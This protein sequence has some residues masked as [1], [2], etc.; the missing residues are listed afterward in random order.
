MIIGHY[1]VG[2]VEALAKPDFL[3]CLPVA[4]HVLHSGGAPN[5]EINGMNNI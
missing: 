1:F 3:W 4:W 2:R 5:Q